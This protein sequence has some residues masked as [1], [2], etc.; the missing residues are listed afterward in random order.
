MNKIFLRIYDYLSTHRTVGWI[1]LVISVALSVLLFSRMEYNEDISAFLPQNKETLKYSSVYKKL[2]GQNRI[3]VFFRGSDKDSIIFAMER[4]GEVWKEKDSTELVSAIQ[5]RV[6]DEQVGSVVRF[7]RENFPYFLDKDDYRRIDSLLTAPGYFDKR[8]QDAKLM[9]LYPSSSFAADYISSDPLDLFSPVYNKLSGLNNADDSNLVYDG[10]IFVDKGCTGVVFMTSPFGDT[11]S[12]KNTLIVNLLNQVI[13]SVG[14]EFPSVTVSATGG[15]VIAVSNSSRIKKDSILSI[16][17]SVIL[18]TLVLSIS[19]RSLREI[20]QIGV[21]ILCGSLFALGLIAAFKTEISLIILG[22]GSIIIGIAV[23]YPLHYIDHLKHQPDRKAALKDIISPLLTGNITTVLAFLSLYLLKADAL[24]DFGLT[25]ALVLIGTILFVIIFLPSLMGSSRVVKQPLIHFG[26]LVPDEVSGKLFLPFVLITIV[27]AFFSTK[28]EFDA[29]L[30]NINYMTDTQK[31]DLALLSSMSENAGD[32]RIW[33]VTESESIDS[34]LVLNE[35][36]LSSLSLPYNVTSIS[37]LVPSLDQQKERLE[38]WEKFKSRYPDLVSRLLSSA[39]AAGFST[40]AFDSFKDILSDSYPLR[41]AEWFSPLFATVGQT[42]VLKDSN[43]TSLVNYIN[44]PNTETEAVKASISKIIANGPAG[45]FSFVFD[46]SDVSSQ[47]ASLL[48]EDFDAIGFVCGCIVF[49]FLWLSF[50]RIE[51]S[52]LSFLPLAVSWICIL[53][54]MHI[55]GIQFNIVNIIL[56]TFIF[57]QGDDYTIFITEGLMYEYAY[58]KKILS[59]YRNSVMLSAI[60][61]FIGIGSLIF[62]GHPA[63]KSL[64]QVTI[65]GMLTVV[66][67]AFYLPPLVFK[68]L[69]YKNGVRREMP[70]TLKRILRSLFAVLFFLLAVLIIVPCIQILFIGRKHSESK[71]LKLHRFLQKLANFVIHHI[72]GAKFHLDNSTGEDFSKPAVIVCNHQSHLDVMCLMSMAPKIVILTNDWVWNN[73]FYRGIIRKAE[74][75]PVSDGFNTNL[76]R[77]EDLVKRGYSVVVFPEGTRSADC[78]IGRF[79][80]GAFVLAREL[81][82]D[83]LPVVLHGVGHVLPKKDMMLRPGQ[84]YA[85]VLR[86]IS[87]ASMGADDK[88]VTKAF[89]RFYIEQYAGI[90]S[91]IETAS[92]FKELVRHSYI[93]KGKNIEKAA[94]AELS[95]ADLKMIDN[96][97]SGEPAIL[98]T[99]ATGAFALLFALARK[100]VEVFVDC[101][102]QDSRDLIA[103]NA[104]VPPNLHFR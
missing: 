59:S 98:G 12:G 84:I 29:D 39:S 81:G 21:S 1:I 53:G 74:F 49:F 103:S 5:V 73:I 79:H 72:P 88:S 62:A 26:R 68:P 41:D 22:I 82:V 11:E 36:L 86:R 44:V 33:L 25:G 65:I 64:A 23:N 34:A 48:S 83:I 61:M 10:Y 8:L 6:D 95:A 90:C 96:W 85:K 35:K 14:S 43:S 13:Y 2:G 3:A 67:M 58:G 76:T 97:K 60:I 94:A 40:K 27:L 28:S 70:V 4:F 77:L 30:R 92:Y 19:F 91:E 55:F 75:Y 104:I 63:M 102:D 78:S 101:P 47:M 87:P 69:V 31:A 16:I 18:I 93:Y 52:I 24:H 46:S 45:Q 66:V 7:V 57:G 54:T 56:A 37:N 71:K 38:E 32:T 50:G 9:L 51:L 100:D 99:S 20:V 80:K 89:R 17:L 42:C 15:P